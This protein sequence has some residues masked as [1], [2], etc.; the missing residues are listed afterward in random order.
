MNYIGYEI[1][2]AS[3]ASDFFSWIFLL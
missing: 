1:S 3:I 2:E